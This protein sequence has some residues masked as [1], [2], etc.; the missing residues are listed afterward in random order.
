MTTKQI[1]ALLLVFVV[2]SIMSAK[3][4]EAGP[5]IWFKRAVRRKRAQEGADRRALVAQVQQLLPQ[6]NDGNVIFSNHQESSASGGSQFTILS[7]TYYPMVF[8]A[9]GDSFWVIPVAYQRWKRTYALGAPVQFSANDV[10][11]ISLTGKRGKTMTFTFQLELDGRK[12]E[13]NMDITPFCFRKN[14]FYPFDLMQEA[15]CDKA[16][17]LAEKMAFAACHLTPEALEAGRLKDE[18]SNYGLYAACAGVF[19]IMFT[20]TEFLPIVLA[21]FGISLI[22]FVV[23]LAKKQIPKLSAIVVL[24][25]AVIAYLMMK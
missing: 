23:M 10:R 24:I 3:F 6:A 12:S 11:E 22:L 8:V 1:F 25:E 14:A 13:I 7:S 17:K 9:D 19:G 16:T 5:I 18:C 21:C 20:P 15:A 2:G 4:Y